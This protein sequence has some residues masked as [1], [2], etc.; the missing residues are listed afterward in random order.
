MMAS[1][2]YEG[3]STKEGAGKGLLRRPSPVQC[4]SPGPRRKAASCESTFA[5]LESEACLG[6]I[7]VLGVVARLEG[8]SQKAVAGLDAVFERFAEMGVLGA[9]L[10][11]LAAQ[12]AALAQLAGD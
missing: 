3:R 7:V 8:G 5:G 6:L 4:T 11:A 1:T 10:V 2:K 9:Q 12:L